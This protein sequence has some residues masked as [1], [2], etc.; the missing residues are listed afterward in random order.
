[1]AK[2]QKAKSASVASRRRIAVIGAVLITFL[3]A[4]SGLVASSP[5]FA[6]SRSDVVREREESEKKISNLE[7]VVDGLSTDLADMAI[8]VEQSKI[9]VFDLQIQLADAEQKLADAERKHSQLVDQLSDAQAL[10]TEIDQSIK[11]SEEQETVLQ[12]AVGSMARE[13]YRGESVSPF[14]VMVSTDD[15]G[16]ISSQA[17]AASALGRVQSKA[18]DEVR[19]GLVVSANQAEKQKAVTERITDLEAKAEQAAM[20]A[21]AARDNV[22]SNLSAVEVKLA[23]QE[24]LQAEWETRRTEAAAEMSS[25]QADRT[26]AIARIAAID[27][28]AAEEAARKAAEEAAKNNSGSSGG[29]SGGGGSSGSGSGS[30]GAVGSGMFKNPLGYNGAINSPFG[31]RYDPI[32]GVYVL[33]NGTDFAAACGAPQYAARE[34]TVVGSGYHYISGNY[35]QINHGVIGGQSYITEYGH[36]AYWPNVSV[37]Q[38]VTTSTLIGY[39]G[40]TGWSTGCHMHLGLYIDGTP[41][42]ILPYM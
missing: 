11:D 42:N 35:V 24:A 20:D 30:G 38:Y 3:M 22:A 23:E 18:M 19:T 27:K 26:D 29:S 39:T 28:A 34:G 16:D 4:L 33:H 5:A 36:F 2:L 15:L 9:D 17:A 12:T 32:S 25:A 14:Q 10:K 21:G 1:M 8:A 13:M 31:Y 7:G 40:T 6:E 37:G 41:V